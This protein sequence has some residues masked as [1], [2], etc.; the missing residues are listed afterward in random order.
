MKTWRRFSLAPF[1]SVVGSLALSALAYQQLDQIEARDLVQQ[2]QRIVNSDCAYIE[3]A[4][5][6]AAEAAIEGRQLFESSPNVSRSAFTRFVERLPKRVGLQATNW[7]R[8]C[9]LKDIAKVESDLAAAYG[10]TTIIRD[11]VGGVLVPAEPATEF[12][13]ISYIWPLDSNES[14]IGFN[15]LSDPARREAVYRARDTGLVAATAPVKVVQEL[16]GSNAIIIFAPHYTYGAS[17]NTI[18]ERREHFQGCA[19]ATLRILP[20]LNDAIRANHEIPQG[21]DIVVRDQEIVG[22]AGMLCAHASRLNSSA[23]TLSRLPEPTT[24]R[25]K[26]EV[27]GR[28]FEL[29]GSANEQFASAHS[30]GR[31]GI[32]A[33]A[34]IVLNTGVFC[35]VRFTSHQRA[36]LDAHALQLLESEYLRRTDAEHANAAKSKFLAVMSHELRTPLSGVIGLLDVLMQASLKPHQMALAKRIQSSANA[37]LANLSEVLDFSKIEANKIALAIEPLNLEEVV[38]APCRLLE[39]LARSK[40]IGYTVFIDPNFPRQL[41]GDAS[42][43]QQI[44]TNFLS[45]AIKFSARPDRDGMIAVRAVMAD[46]DE[47]TGRVWIELSVRDQGVGMGP[48]T[49][50]RLFKPYEQASAVT[51]RQFGGTGLGLSIC[52]HLA[53]LMD[54]EIRAESTLNEGSMF[55][56]RFPLARPV[57]F[58][59]A[60]AT[61][62]HQSSERPLAGL[63]CCVAGPDSDLTQDVAAYLTHAG[64]KVRFTEATEDAAATD[65]S[66][67]VVDAAQLRSLTQLR[68]A[69]CG[70]VGDDLSVSSS[71]RP[72]Y[73]VLMRGIRRRPRFLAPNIVQ[74]DADMA[75]REVIVHSVAVLTGRAPERVED[76]ALSRVDKNVGALEGQ[77]V[78]DRQPPMKPDSVAAEGERGGGQMIL[79]AEDNDVMQDV[80]RW[81]LESLGY[82]VDVVGDGKQAF[83]RWQT[84]EYA[85]VATDL[86]MPEMDGQQLAQAIRAAESYTSR[87]RTPI[88]ALTANALMGET[89]AFYKAAGMDGYLLKP[90]VLVELKCVLEELIPRSGSSPSR[91][92]IA[93]ASR[94][95]DPVDVR[96]LTKQVGENPDRIDGLLHSFRTR[97]AAIVKQIETAGRNQQFGEVGA[98]GHKL[99]SSAFSV[100]ANQLGE[101]CVT[102]ERVGTASNREGTSN[103]IAALLSE[104]AVVEL[105]LLSRK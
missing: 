79:V 81:Q 7:N 22:D 24:H 72:K 53:R 94:Q 12:C 31:L 66:C 11:L 104:W 85:L 5:N 1:I 54:G 69:I 48:E 91:E 25:V 18:E 80:I 98:L 41:L 63:E 15:C 92:P 71:S 82:A 60:D 23:W 17:L 42:R 4:I 78:G 99:K 9:T 68:E 61:D 57:P 13:V 67:F 74:L 47:Q 39:A 100:G 56:V 77:P 59:T 6:E 73:F 50:T 65:P 76:S 102:L 45:N 55:T 29:M 35:F 2:F 96:V 32:L 27:A 93:A 36:R 101:I 28:N 86:H 62:V 44:L 95:N 30:S 87:T 33:A 26:F 90:V 16:E 14:A 38:L 37:L 89:V 20:I 19:V 64:A 51:S 84:R 34:L 75:T 52:Q 3:H 103:A 97:S 21:I 58:E 43:I 49:L 40:R 10:D 46:V 83:E 8:F 105:F 88:I 70:F